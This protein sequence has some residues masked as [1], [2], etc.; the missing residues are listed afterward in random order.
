[1]GG[2]DRALS[3]M[4]VV[5]VAGALWALSRPASQPAL[6]QTPTPSPSPAEPADLPGRALYLRDCAWCHGS[7][8]EGSS[9]GPTLGGVGTASTDFMVRTGRMPIPRPEEQPE[10]AEVPYTD[11]QIEELVAFV[12]TLTEAQAEGPGIP[13]LDV[14]AGDI[15]EGA[16]LYEEHCA[17]CHGALGSGGALT[18][19]LIAPGL[20]HSTPV[21]VAEAIRIGGAGFLSG[22]MPKF[23][24]ESLTDEQ[25][26]S[27]ARY[28]QYLREPEDRGG[29]DLGH[30]GPIPE[31]FVAWAVGLLALL[32]VIRWIGTSD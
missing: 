19:G 23:G 6:A 17:A 22:N 4:A 15:V 27:L 30:L 13:S 20:Q 5:A 16:G 11:R 26:N 29:Q 24:P 14:S 8:G 21:E 18:N 3:V 2:R 9:Y 7:R 25:V 32:V 1:M 12:A 28:V 10:R 31:G